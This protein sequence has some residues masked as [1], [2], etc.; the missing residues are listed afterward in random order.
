MPYR[1]NFFAKGSYY[2]V[3]NRGVNHQDIFYSQENYKY[4]L[5]LLKK[6]SG[7]YFISIIAYCLMPNHYH[8]LIRQNTNIPISTF[9]KILF[10]SYVQALNKQIG[11]SGPLFEGRYK[12]VLVDKHEYLVHLVRYIHLNPVEAGFVNNADDYQF[13]NYLEWI[14]VRTGT[15]IDR[16]FIR[17][18]F[19]DLADYV[20]F[21]VDYQNEKEMMK[22]L[23]KYLFD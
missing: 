10:N 1:G 23:E 4:C 15:I 22:K 7:R 21:V 6:Y 14:G 17:Q 20:R 2:H 12:H 8:F 18:Y 16:D 13:S 5:R 3:F 11:R 9:I 19:P